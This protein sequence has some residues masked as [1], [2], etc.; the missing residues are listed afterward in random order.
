MQT[1]GGIYQD[2]LGL[3]KKKKKTHLLDTKWRYVHSRLLS[4]CFFRGMFDTT[5]CQTEQAEK[6]T[7]LDEQIGTQIDGPNREL[8]KQTDRLACTLRFRCERNIVNSYMASAFAF[9]SSTQH[10]SFKDS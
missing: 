2:F 9:A 7:Q 5:H 8:G 1:V 3:Q 10:W 4:R 6:R